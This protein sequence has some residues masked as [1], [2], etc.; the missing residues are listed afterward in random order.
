MSYDWT[1]EDN[2]N[3]SLSEGFHFV[4][5][6]G[7]KTAKNDGNIY[8]SEKTG[9]RFIFAT[10][11]DIRSGESQDVLLMIEGKGVFNLKRLLKFAGADMERMKAAGVEPIQFGEPDFARKQLIGR[12]SWCKAAMKNGRVNLEWIAEDDVP[13]ATIK[14]YR[15]PVASTPAATGNHQAL[16]DE[17]IPFTHDAWIH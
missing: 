2:D 1:A 11:E 9:D 12:R 14:E 8:T 7:V 3:P 4:E 13:P 5:V 17:N 15:E 16:A 10:V 6:T